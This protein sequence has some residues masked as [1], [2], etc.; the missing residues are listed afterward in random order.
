M[1]LLIQYEKN[2][3]KTVLWTEKFKATL[4]DNI[5]RTRAIVFDKKA[6]IGKGEKMRFVWLTRKPSRSRLPRQYTFNNS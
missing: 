2:P 3:Q 1:T 4:M 6:I 5:L